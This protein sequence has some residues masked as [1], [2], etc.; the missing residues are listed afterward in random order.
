MLFILIS[1]KAEDFITKMEYAKM[2]YS[3]PRG[4]GCISCHGKKGEGSVL[5]KYKHKGKQKEL[6]APAINSLSKRKFFAAF[7][8][9]NSVMPKYFLTKKEIEVLYFYVTSEVNR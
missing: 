3:N 4:I 7:K 6:V 8:K 5:A 9:S 1:L 2:L